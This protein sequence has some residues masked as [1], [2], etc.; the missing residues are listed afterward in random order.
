MRV[1][2]ARQ[3]SA[4][5]Y[6][7]PIFCS[8]WPELPKTNFRGVFVRNYRCEHDLSRHPTGPIAGNTSFPILL[9]GNTAGKTVSTVKITK[10][11]NGALDP[12]TPLWA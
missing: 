2:V 8:G 5:Y 10:F 9:V 4:I 3:A 7:A 12:V 11:T 6:S 1:S